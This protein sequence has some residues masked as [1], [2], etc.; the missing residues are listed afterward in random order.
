MVFP[1]FFQKKQGKEGQGMGKSIKSGKSG[2]E[3]FARKVGQTTPNEFLGR[4]LWSL[5]FLSIF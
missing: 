2:P 4:I 5:F 1:A 3:D